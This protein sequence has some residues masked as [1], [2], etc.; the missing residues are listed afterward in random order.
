[1][2]GKLEPSVG[3][4]VIGTAAFSLWEA[5]GR[6]APALS[7]CREAEPDDIS[8]RQALLDADITVGTMA[9]VIGVSFAFLT[10]DETA[11]L[12]MLV[13]FGS[14]SFLHHWTLAAEP[15]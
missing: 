2:L 12:I 3:A 13:I 10:R 5:W 7:D 8:T 6:N 9:L 14:L 1:M 4:M 11:L 15:R